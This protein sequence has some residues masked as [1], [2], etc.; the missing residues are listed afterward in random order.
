MRKTESI[1]LGG[2]SFTMED[3][4][5]EALGNYLDEIQK[6]LNGNSCSREIMDD[7]EERIAEL[8]IERNCKDTVI[9]ISDVDY[10]RQTIGSP[11]LLSDNDDNS[12]DVKDDGQTAKKRVFRNLENRKLGGVCSG[13][14]EYFNVDVI[15]FRLAFV[16][17]FATGF[18]NFTGI[19][20]T[21][22]LYFVFW[23]IIPPAK[24]VEERCMMQGKRLDLSDFSERISDPAK[25]VYG[26]MQR[27]SL[28]I[29]DAPAILAA[30]RFFKTLAGVI[31]TAS[32]ILILVTC[33][34][35]DIVPKLIT[36][37]YLHG[38]ED[39]GFLYSLANSYNWWLVLGSLIILSIWMI[40][41]G[42]IF[43]FNLKSPKWKPGTILFIVW[44]ISVIV[45]AISI[46]RNLIIYNMMI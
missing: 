28:D 12:G 30:Q 27:N 10:I 36:R 42:I 31:F 38:A 21:V 29:K 19:V 22:V 15:I 8:F 5:L 41:N 34:L 46:I 26:K 25:T 2:Y 16:F 9:N 33:S 3:N 7:I 1:S 32:G 17:L 13:F 37:S 11:S 39:I 35:Y 18:I 4:A 45:L 24:T 44:L 6:H 43:V 23:L 20:A 14:A 40:Y